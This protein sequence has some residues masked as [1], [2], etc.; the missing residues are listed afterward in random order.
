MGGRRALGDSHAGRIYLDTR[1]LPTWVECNPVVSKWPPDLYPSTSKGLVT[2]AEI[3]VLTG[4]L[5]SFALIL[6]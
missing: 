6:F 5:D 1:V 4:T 2:S 3:E